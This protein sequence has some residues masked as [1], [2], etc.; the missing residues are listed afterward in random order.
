MQNIIT[1]YDIIE[2]DP[3][4]ETCFMMGIIF[5]GMVEAGAERGSNAKLA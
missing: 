5:V 3:F 4:D 1:V 2:S